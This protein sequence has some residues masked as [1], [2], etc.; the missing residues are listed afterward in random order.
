MEFQEREY[1]S[2]LQASVLKQDLFDNTEYELVRNIEKGR[3]LEN[4]G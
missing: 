2:N 3:I 4:K 1:L